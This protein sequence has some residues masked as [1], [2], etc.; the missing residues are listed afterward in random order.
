MNHPTIDLTKPYRLIIR[1]LRAM[2]LDLVFIAGT[3]PDP[4]YGTNRSQAING[5][6]IMRM[7]H[8]RELSR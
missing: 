3:R 6:R 2:G 4:T 7:K 1:A 5:V 8:M